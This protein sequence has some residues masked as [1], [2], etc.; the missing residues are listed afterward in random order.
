M[1]E[2]SRKARKKAEKK[3]KKAKEAAGEEETEEERK[4]RKAAKK[5]AKKAQEEAEA[6]SQQ[7]EDDNGEGEEGGEEEFYGAPDE[8]VWSDKSAA[9]LAAEKAAQEGDTNTI[10]THD[11]NGKKLS[12]KERKRLQKE[13]DKLVR[14][15]E[16]QKAAEQ[17]ER[18]EK[19]TCTEY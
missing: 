17:G 15:L 10:P 2:Q 3:A 9:I 18:A 12:N 4:A 14:D 19:A 13:K 7:Q 6:A 16:Y 8:A 5:A 11:K 1:A